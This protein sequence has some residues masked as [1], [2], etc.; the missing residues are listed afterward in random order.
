LHIS[1]VAY[2][3]WGDVRPGIALGLA[4]KEAGYGV[5]LIVTEDFAMWVNNT[6]L[7]I[8]LLPVN[9]FKVMKK[10]STKTNPLE[11]MLAVHRSITPAV[12]R[13]GRDLLALAEDTDCFLVNEWLLGIASGIAEVHQLKLVN[14]ATQPAIK[15]RQM[16][17]STMPLLPYWAP[18]RE[19][20]NLLSYD[21]A[22]Y[23]HWV[24]YARQE[25]FLRKTHLNIA[26]LSPR[27]YLDLFDRIPSITL[28]S[29][30]VI[31]RPEDWQAHHHL[32]GFLFYDD[33]DWLPPAG[34]EDFIHAGEAP[35]YVGFG[36]MHHHHPKDT[37]RLILDALEHDHHRAVLYKGWADLGQSD[38][39]DSVYLLG[40]APHSWL[41]PRMAAVVHH[42]GSGTS[43][44]A[45]RAG[46]PSVPIPHSGDQP[47]WARRLYQIGAGTTP[48]PRNRLNAVDLAK[49]ITSAVQDPQ[50]RRRAVDLCARISREDGVGR[51]V[52]AI[53]DVLQKKTCPDGR[54]ISNLEKHGGEG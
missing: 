53:N 44:A 26:A 18:F 6:G 27:E 54:S 1:I 45:L 38:L 2:G 32:T 20:Y 42:A 16:P 50:L 47:F 7:D 28:I 40:Y 4:L 13:A 14:L 15:T 25:S 9:Q 17:S 24:S 29:Q 30:H 43:A 10:V 37:T 8:H 3:T 12:C 34:L 41:F 48:L 49:R 22:H 52:S 19:V 11:V 23:L 21:F 51:T 46:V 36:S 35:V 31:P 39:P 33:K 5:R